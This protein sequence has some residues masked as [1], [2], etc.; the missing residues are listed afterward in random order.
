MTRRL[1]HHV[2]DCPAWAW[3]TYDDDRF[4]VWR[5]HTCGTDT[6]AQLPPLRICAHC[7]ADHYVPPFIRPRDGN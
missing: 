2:Q 4:E 3:P 6:Y 5:C 7:H 1:A